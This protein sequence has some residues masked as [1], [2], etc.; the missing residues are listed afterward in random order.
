ML[1]WLL[2]DTDGL[3][4][5]SSCCCCYVQLSP[6]LPPGTLEGVNVVLA[7]A[8]SSCSSMC[9]QQG[10]SCSQQHLHFLNSCD[11]LRESNN[12][13]AGCIEEEHAGVCGCCVWGGGVSRTVDRCWTC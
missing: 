6:P 9:E 4:S 11:R 3:P 12:C 5:S 2:A 1:A 8:G 13:E 10:M 7:A